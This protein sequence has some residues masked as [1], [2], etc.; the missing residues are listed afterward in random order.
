MK[1]PEKRLLFTAEEIAHQVRRLARE[2]STDYQGRNL[3]VL[4]VL[5]G[6][7]I[8]LADLVRQLTIPV[9]V[10]FVRLASY[11]AKTTSSGQVRITTDVELDLH[12][13]HILIVED[14]VDSGHTMAFLCEHLLAHEP[15]SLRTC[16]LLD[17]RERRAKTVP[18]DYVALQLQKGF[19]V[20]YGLDCN[21]AGRHFADIYELIP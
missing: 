18:I 20:G 13:R 1:R 16:V 5:K 11:G 7:F 14:I 12:Q 19:V 8:F 3:V 17:K 6:S 15:L 4:G 10:N 21:E 2:I 9:E